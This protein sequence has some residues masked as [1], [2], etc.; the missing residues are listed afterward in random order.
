MRS[1]V[2]ECMFLCRNET[3]QGVGLGDEGKG[4]GVEKEKQITL[5]EPISFVQNCEHVPGIL[6]SSMSTHV[7][8][9]CNS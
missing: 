9:P 7:V 5:Y 1:S 6:H 4:G 2:Y 8:L 3:L